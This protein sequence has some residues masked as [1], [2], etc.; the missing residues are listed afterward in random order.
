MGLNLAFIGEYTQVRLQNSLADITESRK[1]N[2]LV[3]I[4]TTHPIFG[5]NEPLDF[6]LICICFSAV[7]FYQA[8]K[9]GLVC[10]MNAEQYPHIDCL[11][12]VNFKFILKEILA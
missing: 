3:N 2:Y 1:C 12:F 6:E 4:F 10:H 8:N 7:F 11:L 9:Y 5:K